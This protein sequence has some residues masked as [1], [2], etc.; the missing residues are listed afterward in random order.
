MC[1]C[2]MP[3][4]PEHTRNTIY[5][6]RKPYMPPPAAGGRKRS[7]RRKGVVLRLEPAFSRV[8]TKLHDER[9]NSCIAPVGSRRAAMN[10]PHATHA[11]LAGNTEYN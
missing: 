7:L 6:K 1:S 5:Y 8:N 9:Q 3:P 11:E 4:P 10:I 2:A